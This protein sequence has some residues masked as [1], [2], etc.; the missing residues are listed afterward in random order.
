M[1][2][3]ASLMEKWRGRTGY[4]RWL[5]SR[6]H[7]VQTGPRGNGAGNCLLIRIQSWNK[8]NVKQTYQGSRET[9]IGGYCYYHSWQG[10]A[11]DD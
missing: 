8:S 5:G 2:A 10:L 3:P 7:N 9:L 4:L 6:L 11:S 1:T